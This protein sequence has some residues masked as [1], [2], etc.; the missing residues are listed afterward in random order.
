MLALKFRLHFSPGLSPDFS[1]IGQQV[2][3]SRASSPFWKPMLDLRIGSNVGHAR[4]VS[5]FH[6][7]QIAWLPLGASQVSWQ[8]LALNHVNIRNR[9]PSYSP[10]G[11]HME[12][13]KCP[14]AFGVPLPSRHSP[15]VKTCKTSS[16]I[17]GWQ[18]K[19]AD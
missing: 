16:S 9:N 15:H 4:A 8:L 3:Q 17:R 7:L 10:A 5:T 13:D 6:S 1:P 14:T 12:P 19:H 18:T 2:C 11:Y